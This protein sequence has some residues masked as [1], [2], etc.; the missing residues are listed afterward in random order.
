[1]GLLG[2][3]WRERA[4]FVRVM[5]SIAFADVAFYIVL[6]FLV[7]NAIRRAPDLAGAYSTAT[8]V[9]ETIGIALVLLAGRLSDRHGPQPVMRW[10][11]LALAAVLIPA[12][13]LMQQTSVAGLWFGQLLAVAPLMLI[14]G[15]YPSLLP[16]QFPA[17]LRCTGFSLAYSLV[18]AVLGGTAPLLVTWLLGGLGWSW[19]PALYTLLWLPACLWALRGLRVAAGG[20]QG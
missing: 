5:A 1:V 11:C 20:A 9:N 3:L 18:V 17:S 4:A 15:A 19:G 6:V 8:A 16:E 12:S 13:L 2:G 7:Q 14:C 10:S